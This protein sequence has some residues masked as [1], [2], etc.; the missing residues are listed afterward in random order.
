MIWQQKYPKAVKIIIQRELGYI[1]I[2]PKNNWYSW[3]IKYV[4]LMT[5][6]L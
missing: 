5:Y 6:R 3:I 1:N 4:I 2:L